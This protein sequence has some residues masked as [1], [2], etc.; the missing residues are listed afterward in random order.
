MRKGPWQS[1]SF[2]FSL[3]FFPF[4]FLINTQTL[5]NKYIFFLESSSLF[6]KIKL[7]IKIVYIV[8]LEDQQYIQYSSI[9]NNQHTLL[10]HKKSK[11]F[12]QKISYQ[13]TTISL[14]L[15]IDHHS[16]LNQSNTTNFPNKSVQPKHYILI[17]VNKTFYGD[18]NQNKTTPSS[19]KPITNQITTTTILPP[20]PIIYQKYISSILL[21]TLDS[22]LAISGS[23]TTVLQL[24]G[25]TSVARIVILS[26]AS[27]AS[28]FVLLYLFFCLVF[29]FFQFS[30]SYSLTYKPE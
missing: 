8:D 14:T 3:G 29:S 6:Q 1:T 23:A 7:Y 20:R 9:N 21:Y 11:N 15:S 10:C 25:T 16:K 24:N 30:I 12:T 22:S 4:L 5:L 27:I 17:D 19:N 26:K 28:Q 18:N 2:I 13:K